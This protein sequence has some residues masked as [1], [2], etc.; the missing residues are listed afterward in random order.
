MV[1]HVPLCSLA[2][3]SGSAAMAYND[4]IPDVYYSVLTVAIDGLQMEI[5]LYPMYIAAPIAFSS[6]SQ[7]EKVLHN[8]CACGKTKSFLHIAASMQY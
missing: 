7:M 8:I 1:L 2:D 5:L 3:R 6:S 4:I